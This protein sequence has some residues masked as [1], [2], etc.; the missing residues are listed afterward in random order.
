MQEF[1]ASAFVQAA[2]Q[3]MTCVQASVVPATEATA[4]VAEA[5]EGRGDE[6][7]GGAQRGRAPGEAVP[8]AGGAAGE[9]T[10][11]DK[12][13]D[14]RCKTQDIRHKAQGTRHQAHQAIIHN[15][16]TEGRGF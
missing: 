8:L 13:Q 14:Q 11:R 2:A 3:Q 9:V 16:R 10:A 12:T 5:T 1:S 4:A 15:A 6:L 7:A